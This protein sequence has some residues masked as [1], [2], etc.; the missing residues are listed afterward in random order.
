MSALVAIWLF[1]YP[2]LGLFFSAALFNFILKISEFG[3]IYKKITRKRIF[4]YYLLY[5]LI[6]ISAFLLLRYESKTIIKKHQE[7]EQRLTDERI[8]KEYLKL[9]EKERER[10]KKEHKE[11]IKKLV[12][13]RIEEAKKKGLNSK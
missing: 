3:E 9:P 8:H 10:L 2:A 12:E 1:G 7:Y 5:I 6:S 4:L 13:K 11:A